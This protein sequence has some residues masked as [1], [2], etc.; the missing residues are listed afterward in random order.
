M[1]DIKFEVNK[2]VEVNNI[3]GFA[4]FFNL[5]MFKNEF[6]DENYF[7]Y[8]EEIDLCKRV[9]SKAA[10]TTKAQQQQQ[11]QR[12]QQQQQQQQRQ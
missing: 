2:L 4:I 6:F 10:M 12:Q 1:V 7:L 9:K 3:K 11:Q 5:Q 8:F